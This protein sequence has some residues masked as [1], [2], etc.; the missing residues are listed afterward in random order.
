MNPIKS[1]ITSLFLILLTGVL[2]F[3]APKQEV[4][5]MNLPASVIKD[6]IHKTLPLNFKIQS[7]TLLGSVSIDK[8]DNLQFQRNKLSSHITLS[9][10]KLNLVTSIAGHDLRM[11]IGSLTM[12]FQCD[13]TIRF[14]VPSQTLY[15]KP[16]ITELQSTDAP[17]TDIAST[18]VL[19][20]NNIEFPLQIEKL[21][22]IVT[23]TG[24][25]LLNIS[26]N[27][28]SIELRPDS[29]LLSITPQIIATRK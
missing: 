21:K 8:I 6:A 24:D 11:K 22:P 25:K 18:I 28:A 26:M 4:I 5:T 20:F 23:D 27:I 3:A 14:D 13:A 19:L 12:N 2:S 15:L 7:N 17:T 9:G 10:H 16:V 29:L 1:F